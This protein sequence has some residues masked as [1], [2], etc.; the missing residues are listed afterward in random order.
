MRSFILN[1]FLDMPIFFKNFLDETS[2][3]DKENSIFCIF[4]PNFNSTNLVYSLSKK[5]LEFEFELFKKYI[6]ENPFLFKKSFTHIH[7][8]KSSDIQAFFPSITFEE[9]KQF[10][11]LSI[12]N[13]IVKD[14]IYIASV[15]TSIENTSI[16]ELLNNFNFNHIEHFCFN[17]QAVISNYEKLFYLID[18]FSEMLY[19]KDPYMSY[20]M[21]NVA[22]W[23]NKISSKMELSPRDQVVLYIAALFRDVGNLFIPDHILHKPAKL[24]EEEYA[25]VKSHTIK[26]YYV[27]KSMLYGMTFFNDVPDIIKYHH[28]RYD[29]N[30]YPQQLA[31]D[32]IPLL[33]RILSVADTIDAMM[34]KKLYRD[35]FSTHSIVH[36]LNVNAYSKYDPKVVGAA[37][38]LLA[39]QGKEL[40][41][42]DFDTEG[43]RFITNASLSFYYRTYDNMNTIQGNLVIK[44]EM[45]TFILNSSSNFKQEWEKIRIF[46]PTISF[47]ENNNFYEFKCKIKNITD[48]DIE[49]TDIK[50]YSTDKFFSLKLNKE[51]Y[52]ETPLGKLSANTIN[53]GGDTVV[54]RVNQDIAES[55]IGNSII[56]K[57]RFDSEIIINTHIGWIQTRLIRKYLSGNEVVYV[58]RYIDISDAQRDSILKFLFKKQ[59][60][61]N[62]KLTNQA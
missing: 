31:S 29:G 60:Q 37:V 48:T 35:S 39:K 45:A 14:S 26:G 18:V 34:S 17:M 52:L 7:M 42:Y 44:D 28:E 59:I 5:E 9:N 43:S 50:Y 58:C 36:E 38:E 21:T 4:D 56:M 55:T 19:S 10:L 6:T 1:N 16:E 22:N 8:V 46:I 54:F 23:C 57:I 24:T 11:I 62:F 15:V 3:I 53:I 32:E 61:D 33:S 12:R 41:V 25:L 2:I 30:G 20:S 47:F 13:P 49:L 27:L 51:L 40:K